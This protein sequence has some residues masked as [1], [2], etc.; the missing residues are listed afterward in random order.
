MWERALSDTLRGLCGLCAAMA[1]AEGVVRDDG[2]ATG[3][4]LV[5]GTALAAYI[6]KSVER[7]LN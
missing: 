1:L 3:F 4:R 2:A 5:C 7:L 6:L